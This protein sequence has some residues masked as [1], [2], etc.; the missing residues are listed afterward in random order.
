[1]RVFKSRDVERILGVPPHLLT[2]LMRARRLQ[3]PKKDSSGDYV[4]TRD[5]I[6]RARAAIAARRRGVSQKA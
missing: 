4:W 5:D 6:R 1:M 2:Y 3:R